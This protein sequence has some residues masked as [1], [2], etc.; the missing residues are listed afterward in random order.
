MV[1]RSVAVVSDDPGVTVFSDDRTTLGELQQL[2]EFA[3]ADRIVCVAGAYIGQDQK[4]HDAAQRTDAARMTV[5]AVA[6]GPFVGP[7]RLVLNLAT[8]A[9]TVDWG[10]IVA[11]AMDMRIPCL[12]LRLREAGTVVG[13]RYLRPPARVRLNWSL[14]NRVVLV[15]AEYRQACVAAEPSWDRPIAVIGAQR[16]GTT[17][18][19]NLLGAL[20][21][22]TTVRERRTFDAII[23]GWPIRLPRPDAQPTFHA[24]FLTVCR[25]LLGSLA[26]AMPLVAVVRPP[27]DIVRSMLFH[28]RDVENVATLA[29]MVSRV[30]LPR[31][32]LEQA[33]LVVSRAWDN[34][35]RL[36]ANGA[37]MVVVEYEQFCRSP[38]QTLGAVAETLG[39]AG[40]RRVVNERPTADF[41]RLSSHDAVRV[42]RALMVRFE[43]LLAMAATATCPR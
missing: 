2:L 16:S 35:L 24:T 23:E 7:S 8:G 34:L 41:P 22:R 6:P 29:A 26:A 9:R 32:P 36:R 21:G 37:V 1:E 31:D 10:A 33:I 12:T 20:P 3:G 14:A 28:W 27:A 30:T 42:H 17:A 19:A 5:D 40:P 4:W 13:H 15:N 25:G 39:L 11:R 43:Q 18:L 38:E